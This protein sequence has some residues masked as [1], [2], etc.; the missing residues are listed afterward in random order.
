MGVEFTRLRLWDGSRGGKSN[1]NKGDKAGK[2]SELHFE[3]N[4]WL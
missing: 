1:A 4:Y 3:V 2:G